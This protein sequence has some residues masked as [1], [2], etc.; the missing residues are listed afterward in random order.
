MSSEKGINDALAARNPDAEGFLAS[1]NK[2]VIDLID[3]FA[4]QSYVHPGF[5]GRTSIKA[6]LPALVP[7]LSYESLAIQDGAAACAIWNRLV[8]GRF[9]APDRQKSACDLL[10]Y[11]GQDTRAMF[12]IWNIVWATAAAHR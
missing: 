6:V 9:D 5:K 11:C 2:R 7:A 3:I 12:E 1:V 10:L 8:S 4:D